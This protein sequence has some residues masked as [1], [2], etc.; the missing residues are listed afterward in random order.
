[1]ELADFFVEYQQKLNLNPRYFYT[2]RTCE[3]LG[4]TTKDRF[5]MNWDEQRNSV[6]ILQY[7]TNM[8]ISINAKQQVFERLLEQTNVILHLFEEELNNEPDQ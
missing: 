6:H 7:K 3:S 1:M 5:S 4:L 8:L 2:D